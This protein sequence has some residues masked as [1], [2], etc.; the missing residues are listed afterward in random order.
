MAILHSLQTE[1][2]KIENYTYPDAAGRTGATGFTA[3]DLGK[4][5]Y[6]TDNGTYWRLTATTP[7]WAQVGGSGTVTSVTASA[8]LT[9]SGGAAPNIAFSNQSAHTAMMGPTSGGAAAPT[10]RVPAAADI[11]D[12]D[13]QVR[14]STL[15][16]MTAPTADLSINSHKLTNVTDP[17][18][19]QD[20]ATK[21][22]VDSI[23][24]GGSSSPL[25]VFQPNFAPSSANAKDNNFTSSIADFTDFDP[26]AL[27]TLSLETYGMKQLYAAGAAYKIAGAFKTVP[28]SGDWAVM[29]QV[30][31]EGELA[32]YF[33]AGIML[34]QDLTNNPTTSDIYTFHL[35]RGSG[36]GTIIQLDKWTDYQTL[37]ATA[38][39]LAINN[40][41]NGVCLRLRYETATT[42]VY[43]EFSTDNGISWAYLGA[44]TTL[45]FT[46]AEV[47]LSCAGNNSKTSAGV[48]QYFRIV[49]NN[50][51]TV[52]ILGRRL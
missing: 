43:P 41:L 12:F 22:Y 31:I 7:T 29:T 15:N 49:A 11:S 16:Q 37:S 24:P 46:P 27:M 32:N 17:A 36:S 26:G 20:A 44:S 4:I 28:A 10:F 40:A 47:G 9:S 33:S 48:W 35:W 38:Q 14:T 8:P 2:H 51:L 25:N 6:Q 52:P 3:D 50:T 39:S 18:S 23:V 34:G 1:N 19:N 13:T 5:A 42:K 30:S 45:T 21:I